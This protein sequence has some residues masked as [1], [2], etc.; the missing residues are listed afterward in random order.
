MSALT[1]PRVDEVIHVGR[2]GDVVTVTLDRPR[3]AN[4]INSE[5]TERLLE[6]LDRASRDGTRAVVL[7]S[8]GKHFCAGFDMDGALEQSEGDL[9][10]RFVRIEQLLQKL[11]AAPFLTIACVA[12]KAIGAGADIAAGCSHRLLDPGATM[13]FPGFRFGVALGTRHLA[14]LIGAAAARD[15]L[16]E[17]REVDASTALRLGLATALVQR[18][19]FADEAEEI[20]RAADGLDRASLAFVLDRT[21]P[22]RA[23]PTRADGEDMAALVASLTRPGLHARLARYLGVDRA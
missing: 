14:S 11:R 8:D 1:D 22:T 23:D 12:G 15:L 9:L 7:R 17:S 10:L 19:R 20:I 4:A 16:L 21:S 18:E 5:L 13:R 6:V 2:T 3:R